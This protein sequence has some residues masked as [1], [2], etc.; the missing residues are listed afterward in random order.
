MTMAKTE[1]IMWCI[2]Y[3]LGR[4]PCSAE[5]CRAKA[6]LQDIRSESVNKVLR[7]IDNLLPYMTDQ[8][9]S[10]FRRQICTCLLAAVN[11][12][13]AMQVRERGT[14]GYTTCPRCQ[15]PIEWDYQSYCDR[16][17]QHLAW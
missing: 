8:E 5:I 6:E 15:M 4:S 13:V 17:G 2:A 1:T 12:R 11:Y 3:A 14:R 9:I 7:S 16:C 10:L